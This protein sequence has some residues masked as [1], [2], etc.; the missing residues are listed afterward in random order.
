MTRVRD[1]EALAELAALCQSG[2]AGSYGRLAALSKIAIIIAA[3]G[4]AVD[5]ITVGDCV[6]LLE[7]AAQTRRSADR[8]ASS[9]FFY[10]L[11]HARGVFGPG[12]PAAMRVSPAAG[13]RRASS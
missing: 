2:A 6:Q 13:S 4:G 10:Q 8:H 12:A 3:K 1:P 5:A 11:L 9:P 7:I